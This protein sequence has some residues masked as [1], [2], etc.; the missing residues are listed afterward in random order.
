MVF[1]NLLNIRFYPSGEAFGTASDD[2]TVSYSDSCGRGKIHF[3]N[4]VHVRFQQ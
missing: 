4:F 2:A 3:V 1:E